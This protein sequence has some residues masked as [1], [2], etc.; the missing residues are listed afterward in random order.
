MRFSDITLPNNYLSNKS[1]ASTC[2]RNMPLGKHATTVRSLC[3]LITR[4]EITFVYKCTALASF[5]LLHLVL[6]YC[7]VVSKHENL[8]RKIYIFKAEINEEKIIYLRMS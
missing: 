4:C 8:F 1:K 3:Q 2:L 6:Q 5:I 7:T